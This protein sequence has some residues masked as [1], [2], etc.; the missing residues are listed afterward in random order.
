MPRVVICKDCGERHI[1]RAHGLCVNC[2]QRW[3]RQENPPEKVSHLRARL[4]TA[5]QDV[6]DAVDEIMEPIGGRCWIEDGVLYLEA[7]RQ[8]YSRKIGR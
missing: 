4:A 8:T 7:G 1:H 3:Y 5:W 6:A 2:Y